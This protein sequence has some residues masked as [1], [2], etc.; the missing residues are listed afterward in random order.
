[1]TYET[2]ITLAMLIGVVF[3]ACF[4]ILIYRGIIEMVEVEDPVPSTVI[5]ATFS[6]TP[7]EGLKLEKVDNK[8]D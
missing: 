2:K 3:G 7:E 8:T 1:M 4:G 6:Y 5:H